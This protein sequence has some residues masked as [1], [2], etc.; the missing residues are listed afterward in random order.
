MKT[1]LFEKSP[2]VFN[3]RI[4]MTQQQ[5]FLKTNKRLLL[6]RTHSALST[7]PEREDYFCTD[8]HSHE[9]TPALHGAP[10]HF[11]P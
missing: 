1:C 2:V 5:F 6:K 10:T 11:N 9:I 8:L 7:R 3:Y 4:K